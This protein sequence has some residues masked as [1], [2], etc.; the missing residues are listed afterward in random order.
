MQAVKV[1]LTKREASAQRKTNE[2][3]EFAI[4]QII[5]SAVVSG[6]VVDIF[7]AVAF[8]WQFPVRTFFDFFFDTG[9]DR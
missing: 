3:R 4:R 1:I 8:L 7:S 6:E 2:E 5:S 9:V